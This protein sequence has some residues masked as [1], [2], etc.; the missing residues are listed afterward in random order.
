MVPDVDFNPETG[1]MRLV[2][3]STPE[4]AEDFYGPLVKWLLEYSENAC[5]LTEFHF[6][7]E[8]FNTTSSKSVLQILRIMERIYKEGHNINILW[9]YET[10]DDDMMECGE[11]F[12]SI[13]RIP[14]EF[15]ECHDIN[16]VD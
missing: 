11:D 16:A 3:R 13:V 14:F 1:I 9:Y 7:F 2:G 15:V 8:Y 10:D 6:R 12:Q 4:N 5:D